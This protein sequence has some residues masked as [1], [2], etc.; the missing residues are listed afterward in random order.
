MVVGSVVRANGAV[1]IPFVILLLSAVVM[2]FSVG[3]SLYPHWGADAI[4]AA[5]GSSAIT[6]ALLSIAYYLQGGWRKSRMVAA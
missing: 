3:F 2:R 1:I 5:F 6:S 4:W